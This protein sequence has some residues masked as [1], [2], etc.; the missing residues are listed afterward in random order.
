MDEL[1]ATPFWKALSN[2]TIAD[3]ISLKNEP[4]GL[5]WATTSQGTVAFGLAGGVSAERLSIF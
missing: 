3:M 4:S 2:T 1:P 5:P